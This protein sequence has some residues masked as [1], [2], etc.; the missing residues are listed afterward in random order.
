V[1]K[2]LNF[3]DERFELISVIFRLAGNWEYNVCAGS[4]Y[5]TEF[6][7]TE[8]QY[9]EIS[10]CEFT[11]DYQLE[12]IERFKQYSEHEAVL[13][14]KKSGLGFSDP[15]FFS[16]HL[17]KED[18]EFI[19]IDNITSMF[20]WQWRNNKVMHSVIEKLCNRN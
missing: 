7:F 14:A 3:V 19:F 16:V 8:E 5:N 17:Q 15:A 13:Y 6:P 4:S 12:V 9:A 1:N 2:K 18:G 11:N 10:K 20:H